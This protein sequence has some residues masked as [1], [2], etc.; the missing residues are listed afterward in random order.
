VVAD[1]RQKFGVGLWDVPLRELVPLVRILHRDPTSWLFAVVN[2]WEYPT[3]REALT[4]ADMFDAYVQV[5]TRKGQ[6]PKPYLRPFSPQKQY[7]GR[8][9][10]KRR[11]PEE[12]SALFAN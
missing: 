1:L 8:R 6:R 2:G 5:H 7:G 12:L 3:T 11:T 4:L 10:N 9:K